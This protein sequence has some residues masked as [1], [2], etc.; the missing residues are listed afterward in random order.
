MWTIVAVGVDFVHALLMAAWVAG[1]PLL[2]WHRWPALSRAYGIYAVVFIV[3]SQA[4][5]LL[6]GECFFTT[7][8]RWCLQ[9]SSAPVSDEWFTVR[10]AQAIFHM[11]P[12]HR[13]VVWVSE[14]LILVTAVGMM[15]TE[16]AHRRR[17]LTA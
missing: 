2:F 5:H 6:L 3:F 8:A 1:L 13:S 12:S 14:T 9:A 15:V 16:I 4:S 11:A 7:L 10:M 17:S